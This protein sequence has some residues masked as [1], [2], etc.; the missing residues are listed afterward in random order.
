[1]TVLAHQL[2]DGRYVRVAFKDGERL[3]TPLL[4]WLAVEVREASLV[5]STGS[6]Q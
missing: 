2:R 1:M 5:P 6:R 4:P 3:S